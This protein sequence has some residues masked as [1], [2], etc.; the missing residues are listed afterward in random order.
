MSDE[1]NNVEVDGASQVD[2]PQTDTTTQETTVDNTENQIPD[3]TVDN[4][5]PTEELYTIK[6]QGQDVQLKKDDLIKYAQMGQDY[7]QKT[8]ELASERKLAQIFKDQNLNIDDLITQ[9]EQAQIEEEAQA[10]GLPPEFY[11]EFTQ[12]KQ[13]LESNKWN[14]VIAQQ[15]SKLQNE[16]FY[17]E[18]KKDVFEFAMQRG[19]DLETAYTYLA[20]TKL[21]EIMQNQEKLKDDAVKEYLSKKREPQGVVEGDGS[22]PVV[23]VSQPKTFEDAKAGAL[24]Y[25]K[26]LKN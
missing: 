7:T 24:A 22:T 17:N 18:W 11:Q 2:T 10:A 13:E 3:T 1:I 25:L 15:D 21:P 20:R 5:Q 6:V 16:P 14:G 9:F 4:N 12:M 26:S 23:Q 8:Q 19:V